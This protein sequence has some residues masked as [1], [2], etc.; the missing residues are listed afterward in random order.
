MFIGPITLQMGGKLAKR[1]ES[2]EQK[3]GRMGKTSRRKDLIIFGLFSVLTSRRWLHK[4]KYTTQH[5]VSIRS[6]GYVMV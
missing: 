5:L 4:I 1:V 2:N 3:L 6:H